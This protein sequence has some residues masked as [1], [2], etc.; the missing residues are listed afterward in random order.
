MHAEMLLLFRHGQRPDFDTAEARSELMIVVSRDRC[1][2]CATVFKAL[3]TLVS[4]NVTAVTDLQALEPICE[5]YQS[6]SAEDRARLTTAPTIKRSLLR[7]S[8]LRS[9]EELEALILARKKDGLD[10]TRTLDPFRQSILDRMAADAEDA[11]DEKVTDEKEQSRKRILGGS[12]S[13]SSSKKLTMAGAR[14]WNAAQGRIQGRNA[15]H[16]GYTAEYVGGDNKTRLK[17]DARTAAQKA[18]DSRKE[19]QAGHG[20]SLLKG[21]TRSAAQKAA[22]SIKAR[23]PRAGPRPGDLRLKGHARKGDARTP[24]Q[25]R[26]MAIA[27]RA[28]R[29]KHTDPS[30]QRGIAR[31]KAAA[32][33]KRLGKK[34]KPKAKAKPGD[35]RL[36]KGP[37]RSAAQKAAVSKGVA[38]IKGIVAGRRN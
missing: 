6:L 16:G 24:A 11:A 34:F 27:Y 13:S 26:S 28:S 7:K 33:K 29:L 37:N 15:G 32:R 31:A 30:S 10:T 21:D 2:N 23:G 35:K 20:K 3:E 25:K 1:P 4:I 8:V 36:L 14:A 17:G 18:A 9:L 12:S 22:D 5:Q 19:G 38:V